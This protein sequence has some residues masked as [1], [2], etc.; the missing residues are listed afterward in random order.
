MIEKERKIREKSM[1]A[2]VILPLGTLFYISFEEVGEVMFGE[3]H[4]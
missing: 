3:T 4:Y 2:C 1:C